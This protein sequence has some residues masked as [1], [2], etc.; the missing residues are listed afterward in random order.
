[1]ASTLVLL[2]KT[3][4]MNADEL[5]IRLATVHAVACD[6]LVENAETAKNSDVER[7]TVPFTL[8]DAKLD[9]DEFANPVGGQVIP[10]KVTRYGTNINCSNPTI[11]FFD[12]VCRRHATGSVNLFFLTQKDAQIEI[13]RNVKLFQREQAQQELSTLL[14]SY[15]PYLLKSVDITK[16]AEH[17]KQVDV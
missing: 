7:W 13:D 4:N 6:Y 17:L 9:Y 10:I 14:C 8:Y 11:D 2:L 1:M 16:L 5:L 3:N 15:L 12:P